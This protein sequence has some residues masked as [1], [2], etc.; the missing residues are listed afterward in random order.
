[1][2][3]LRLGESQSIMKN[4]DD[5][6]CGHGSHPRL[7]AAVFGG[8]A[9]LGAGGAWGQT[10]PASAE[11]ATADVSQVEEVVVTALKRDTKLQDTPI[12]ISA[13]SGDTIAK[14]GVQNIGDFAK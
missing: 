8:L 1:M 13:I 5:K 9:V 12:A 4:R 14:S 7:E 10:P 3:R 11:T 6:T 2:R